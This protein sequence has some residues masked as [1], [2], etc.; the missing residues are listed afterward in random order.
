MGSSIVC[1]E[2]SSNIVKSPINKRPSNAHEGISFL[3]V[4][5]QPQVFFLPSRHWKPDR[6][7]PSGH[8]GAK[9][10]YFS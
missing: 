8:W 10:P 6:P 1:N 9:E 3:R 5:H 4:L 7:P 2:A